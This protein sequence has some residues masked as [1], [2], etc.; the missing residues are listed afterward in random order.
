[1]STRSSRSKTALEKQGP[2]VVEELGQ[3]LT[4][5]QFD[6]ANAAFDGGD[7]ILVT[8]E[9]WQEKLSY[10]MKGFYE[11]LKNFNESLGAKAKEK[12]QE[13][14]AQFEDAS[15]KQQREAAPTSGMSMSED[16]HERIV[17][18]KGAN[19]HQAALLQ[20]ASVH[21]ADAK[22]S[23]AINNLEAKYT[24]NIEKQMADLNARHKQHIANQAAEHEKE[25]LSLAKDTEEKA[26]K[27]AD[28]RHTRARAEKAAE[29][30]AVVTDLKTP[31][32]KK[33]VTMSKQMADG[34]IGQRCKDAGHTIIIE[35]DKGEQVEKN[36]KRKGKAAGEP[37]AKVQRTKEQEEHQNEL[38]E[39]R[40]AQKQ[41]Y[42]TL[43]INGPKD[44]H[45]VVTR[46]EEL[47]KEKEDLFA[48]EKTFEE[49]KAGY[50]ANQDVLNT[51]I[52]R[53]VTKVKKLQP[54]LKG[55]IEELRTVGYTDEKLIELGIK[56]APTAANA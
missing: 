50:E 26:T 7:T 11:N 47:K 9:H 36:N 10:E 18:T 30:S 20:G 37:K 33:T 21:E 49:E 38:K 15:T 4:D 46:I 54:R 48:N 16:R 1:M 31:S 28:E 44:L 42:K 53:L 8:N 3:V 43:E 52:E 22:M 23:A 2:N 12:F 45:I 35:E 39:N 19:V 41:I 34:P 24:E 14:V 6:D 27:A 32:E 40:E 13:L 17:A 55:A 25:K 5:K 51:K 56:Q 29:A